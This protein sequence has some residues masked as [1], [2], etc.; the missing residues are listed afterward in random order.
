MLVHG[1]KEKMAFL[2]EKIQEYFGIPCYDPP[3]G[4]SITVKSN[5]NIPLL[6]SERL[7]RSVT[8]C[9]GVSPENSTSVSPFSFK[10]ETSKIA[11]L[12]Q[13]C[14]FMGQPRRLGEKF[15]TPPYS[16]FAAETPKH[17]RSSA[18]SVLQLAMAPRTSLIAGVL[19][20]IRGSRGTMFDT[21]KKNLRTP[22]VFSFMILVFLFTIRRMNCRS[23]TQAQHCRWIRCWVSTATSTASH[24]HSLQATWSFFAWWILADASI[25]LE[26]APFFLSLFKTENIY[27]ACPCTGSDLWAVRWRKHNCRA[28]RFTV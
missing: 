18:A 4:L 5:C 17:V 2:K 13:S 20:D 22:S 21:F 12:E 6:I 8:H 14:E 28:W 1:E 24:S 15:S 25:I 10:L 11:D 23:F 26:W 16:N 9:Y 19:S 3:N 27:R 7:V